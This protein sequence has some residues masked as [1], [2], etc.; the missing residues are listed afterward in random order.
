MSLELK[1]VTNDVKR[2][3]YILENDDKTGK[4]GAIQK[5]DRVDRTV[6]EILTREKIYKAKAATWGTIAG[7]IVSMILMGL[8]SLI[9][10]LSAITF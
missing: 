8:K 7:A 5:I 4:E 10:K 1:E 9:V 3:L 2:I 6:N